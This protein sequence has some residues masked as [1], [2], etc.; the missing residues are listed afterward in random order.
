LTK[1]MRKGIILANFNV[2]VQIF[3]TEVA[4][5][6]TLEVMISRG[7][8]KNR[9]VRYVT[10]EMRDNLNEDLQ[11]ALGF[12]SNLAVYYNFAEN[13]LLGLVKEVFSDIINEKK[14]LR[15]PEKVKFD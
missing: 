7:K 5:K 10:M 11:V 2:R 14:E 12:D 6:S 4:S 15:K 1:K 9:E 3:R 8:G 13:L